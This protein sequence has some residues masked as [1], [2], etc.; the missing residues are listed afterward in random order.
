MTPRVSFIFFFSS[1]RRHTRCSRDWSS[2]VCYSD[3]ADAVTVFAD[4]AR[5]GQICSGGCPFFDHERELGGRKDL[6][7][8]SAGDVGGGGENTR[9]YF[10][11][12]TT[13]EAGVLQKNG[14]WQQTIRAN[15]DPRLS[16]RPD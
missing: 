16:S 15:N 4:S 3:L 5:A 2:D 12:L 11:G 14:Y 1:R 10:S 7:Y 9:D 6:S 13:K 8:E